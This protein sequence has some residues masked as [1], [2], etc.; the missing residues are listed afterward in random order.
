MSTVAY[1]ALLYFSTLSHKRHD[2]KKVTEHKIFSTILFETSHENN[3]A[4]YAHKCIFV[5]VK[6]FVILV[7]FKCNESLLHR[8]S[9][10]Y[11]N[12]KFPENP[13]SDGRV[14]PF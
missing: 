14:V 6:E 4:I 9:K 10:K 5:H 1:P 7:T 8:F 11:S 12:I 13:T 3:W 2:K